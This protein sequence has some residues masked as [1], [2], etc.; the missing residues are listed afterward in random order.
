MRSI[1][2]GAWN[3]TRIEAFPPPRPPST[4][5]VDA[6]AYSLRAM[7]T[8]RRRH[9]IE[10]GWPLLAQGAIA[11]MLS[12]DALLS[13]SS[14]DFTHNTLRDVVSRVSTRYL[15]TP[16]IEGPGLGGLEDAE[17]LFAR[18][19]DVERW[20]HAYGAV[21]VDLRMIDE[22]LVAQPLPPDH[23]D[24]EVEDGK[25]LRLRLARPVWTA[26]SQARYAV[27]EFDLR[28]PEAPIYRQ[29]VK[30]RWTPGEWIWTFEDGRPFIPGVMYRAAHHLDFWGGGHWA[31]LVD[32]TF[33]DCIHWTVYKYGSLNG[34][35]GIP[36]ALDAVPLGATTAGDGEGAQ[37]MTVGAGLL[38]QFRSTSDR[39][40]QVG[41]IQPTFDPEKA[42]EATILASDKRLETLGLGESV[43][44]RSGAESG[45]ALTLRQE[46]LNRLRRTSEALFLRSDREMLR[47]VVALR[48]LHLG[49]PPEGTLADYRV[50]YVQPQPATPTAPGK[51]APAPKDPTPAASPAPVT[52][53]E[54]G[55]GAPV[56]EAPAA[57]QAVQ[58]FHPTLLQSARAERPEE[59]GPPYAG[60]I[61]FQGLRIDIENPK[62]STRSGTN[63]DGTPWTVEM[64]H[65]YGE[66]RGTK[67]ADGDKLD[68]YVGPNH[69]SGLVVVVAQHEPTP[70]GMPGAYDEDK[71]MLGFD[72]VEEA[73][74][75]YQAQYDQ[76][77]FFQ[78][79]DFR[80]M[81]FGQFW[82]IV[83]NRQ[84]RGKRID[85]ISPPQQKS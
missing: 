40:G 6:V 62:G 53:V 5:M 48:R 74:A 37:N 16:Q 50:F 68:V 51:T 44:S 55:R 56:S 69:D 75:A 32:A 82:R 24:A 64:G 1:D 52:A 78:E 8:W 27:E 19:V 3:E 10:G 26:R 29:M 42:V 70:D 28:D 23:V 17:V 39:G 7:Q 35:S 81:P 4:V 46:G 36:Y 57:P 9:F 59:Q 41:L 85:P 2:P 67:G 45:Y 58:N 49:G 76:P 20:T 47:K 60:F 38:A 14:P 61:D 71:A 65:D 22:E 31:E 80:V 83:K 12:D 18:H 11:A 34:G 25:I 73:L 54:Q 15:D 33:E 66:I 77:G 43:F 72:T 79:G 63:P 84:F 21:W 13:M 30:G